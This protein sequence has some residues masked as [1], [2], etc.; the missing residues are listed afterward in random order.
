MAKAKKIIGII[1][2]VIGLISISGGSFAMLNLG[3]LWIFGFMELF[4]G[5]FLSVIGLCILIPSM[6]KISVAIAIKKIVGIILLGIGAVLSI[7]TGFIMTIGQ[8]TYEWLLLNLTMFIG[9]VISV[10]GLIL[11]ITSRKKKSKSQV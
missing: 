3:Y 7:G 4:G 8:W 1:L 9:V 6:K 10:I 5:V 11:L 2:L